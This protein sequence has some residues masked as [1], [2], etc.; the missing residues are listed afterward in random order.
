MELVNND[1]LQAC[2]RPMPTLRGKE[3]SAPRLTSLLHRNHAVFRSLKRTKLVPLFVFPLVFRVGEERI[4]S[5]RSS[6][7]VRRSQTM[8]VSMPF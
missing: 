8:S 5:F 4:D 1:E 7:S 2:R 6:V 3:M